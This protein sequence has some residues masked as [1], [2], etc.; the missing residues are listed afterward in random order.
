MSPE[1]NRQCRVAQTQ[2]SAAATTIARWHQRLLEQDHAHHSRHELADIGSPTSTKT[3][4]RGSTREGRLSR[5]RRVT[6]RSRDVYASRRSQ[7]HEG[8][9]PPVRASSSRRDV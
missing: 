3:E 6:K 9:K 7:Q 2:C 4:H 5:V 8:R 1:A